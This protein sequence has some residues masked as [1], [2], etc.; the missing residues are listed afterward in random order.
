MALKLI[1]QNITG[2]VCIFFF[3][4]DFETWCGFFTC[5]IFQFS[6]KFGFSVSMVTFKMPSSHMWPAASLLANTEIQGAGQRRFYEAAADTEMY[7][8]QCCFRGQRRCDSIQ[9][10][11]GHFDRLR[12]RRVSCSALSLPLTSCVWFHPPRGG[13]HFEDPGILNAS[14]HTMGAGR[15]RELRLTLNS[16]D[17]P[18]GRR[19]CIK[20]KGWASPI[21]QY[22]VWGQVKCA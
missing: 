9:V 7:S 13:V 21:R 12:W 14:S 11:P 18:L 4:I 2:T 10:V 6:S 20:T 19:G 5:S 22:R 15:E 1:E 16:R 17:L 3:H 8:W